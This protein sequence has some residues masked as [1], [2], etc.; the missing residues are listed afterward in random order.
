MAG[1]AYQRANLEYGVEAIAGGE[2]GQVISG[3]TARYLN[4]SL[5]GNED[6]WIYILFYDK[7]IRGF[8]Y[9]RV[10]KAPN[11]VPAR[12]YEGNCPECGAYCRTHGGF[13]DCPIEGCKNHFTST[14]EESGV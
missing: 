14:I 4:S 1:L 8:E 2:R 7:K 10:M 3:N 9:A 11:H 13:W 5:K 6:K 12:T